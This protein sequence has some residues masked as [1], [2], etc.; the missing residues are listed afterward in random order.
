M[1][2]MRGRHIVPKNREDFNKIYNSLKK[3]TGAMRLFGKISNE[4][5]EADLLIKNG[6]II[7]VTCENL[8][9]GEIFIGE[10]ALEKIRKNFIKSG[11]RLDL[12]KFNDKD[13]EIVRKENSKSLLSKKVPISKLGMKIKP[14]KAR[15][16][17]ESKVKRGVFGTISFSSPSQIGKHHDKLSE[18]GKKPLFE[19]KKEIQ[20]GKKEGIEFDSKNLIGRQVSPK[21]IPKLFEGIPSMPEISERKKSLLEKLRKRRWIIDKE[22]AERIS[23]LWSE[24]R[25]EE[26]KGKF[27]DGKVRTTI[28][29]L[30][31]L[32]KKNK[33]VKINDALAR[34][35]NVSRAQIESWAVILEEHNLIELRYPAIGE[36][37]MKII[38][39]K[40]E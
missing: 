32:I 25:K 30:Y 33:T 19:I 1:D 4:F 5:C 7:A 35:L 29:E 14:L 38:E 31:E 26:T 11:G 8:E 40:I 36:P 18:L 22:I 27:D 37:E 28:D 15:V 17:K 6:E 2:L 23:K 20:K 13:L 21:E 24:I 39:K 16:I 9:K 3:F 12:Y 34:K 10:N